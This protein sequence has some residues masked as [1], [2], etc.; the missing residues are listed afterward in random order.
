MAAPGR[1]VQL[2]LRAN[3]A[4]FTLLVAVNALVGAMFGQERWI[5]PLMAEDFF[6]LTEVNRPLLTRPKAR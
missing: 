4:Q 2:G 1:P 5:L 6:G 3:L